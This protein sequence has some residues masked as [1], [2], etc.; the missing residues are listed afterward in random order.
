MSPA[1]TDGRPLLIALGNLYRSDDAV[2]PKLLEDVGH[3]LADRVDIVHH[4]GDPSDL[5]DLWNDRD[6]LIVDAAPL[7]DDAAPMTVFDP[8]GGEHGLAAGR[9]RV[10]SSHALSLAEALDL[11]RLLG[12]LPRTLRVVAVAGE[13]FSFG[14]G[15][16]LRARRG[17]AA[18]SRWIVGAIEGT[19]QGD[20]PCTN[21]H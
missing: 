6:V 1:A 20:R 7:D 8:L 14:E 2:G 21:T 10:T 3:K 18:A 17:M 4:N 12:K 11:G 5:I 15:L 9:G 13:D 16:S 19:T